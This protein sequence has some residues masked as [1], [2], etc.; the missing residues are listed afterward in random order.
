MAST[1]PFSGTTN[2]SL[3]TPSSVKLAGHSLT[4]SSGTSRSSHRGRKT[5]ADTWPTRTV[6][7]RPTGTGPACPCEV[8]PANRPGPVLPAGSRGNR[9]ARRRPRRLQAAIGGAAVVRLG[10]LRRGAGAHQ[11]HQMAAG[12]IA[13]AADAV[14]IDSVAARRWRASR[15][16]PRGSRPIARGTCAW[17]RGGS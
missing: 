1:C 14:G 10:R 13:V 2:N 3:A 5:S 17:A 6:P 4:V 12:R 9:T 15:P 7:A 8:P 11:R 16:R